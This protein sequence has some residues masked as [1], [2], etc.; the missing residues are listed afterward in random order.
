MDTVTAP[1]V[2]RQLRHCSSFTSYVQC[3]QEDIHAKYLHP[4]VLLCFE[5]CCHVGSV[6]LQG[7]SSSAKLLS[8][9]PRLNGDGQ[10]I[11]SSLQGVVDGSLRCVQLWD[12]RARLSMYCYCSALPHLREAILMKQILSPI[13]FFTR[14]E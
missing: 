3:Q 8:T 7:T 11:P 1:S 10:D 9:R 5:S 12:H 2:S 6:F 14:I 4:P 13:F